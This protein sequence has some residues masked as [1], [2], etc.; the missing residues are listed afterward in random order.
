MFELTLFDHLRMTFGH[1]VHRHRMHAEMAHAR[2]RW[3]RMLR[4]A[5]VLLVTGVVVTAIGGAFGQGYGYA[6]ATMILAILALVAL[7]IHLTFDLDSSAHAHAVCATRL[8]HVREKY[9]A[10]LSDLTDSALGLDAVRR[11]RDELMLELREV[12]EDA[13]PGEQ[14]AYQTAGQAIRT[15]DE[16]ALSDEE[17][18]QFLPK[19]L[20][21]A[22]KTARA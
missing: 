14:K 8:W 21:A 4:T 20:Q 1:I 19:S 17:I 13:P 9:R 16:R 10:L 3:D 22:A 11:R 5:E 2:R 6:V 7:L 18:D 12:Y 15:T